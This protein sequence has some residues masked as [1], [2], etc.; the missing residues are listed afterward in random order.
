MLQ[1][2]GG[3]GESRERNKGIWGRGVCIIMG[4]KD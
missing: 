1:R 2:N 4:R 3:E